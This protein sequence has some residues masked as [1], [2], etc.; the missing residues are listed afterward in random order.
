MQI[1]M[2]FKKIK[3]LKSIGFRFKRQTNLVIIFFG[4]G[5]GKNIT[6]E[7]SSIT[8]KALK[9]RLQMQLIITVIAV[10]I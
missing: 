7:R 10:S 2:F 8:K 9:Q 1:S 4:T 3:L 5:L 6:W